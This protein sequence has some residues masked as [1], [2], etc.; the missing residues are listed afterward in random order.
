MSG[1]PAGATSGRDAGLGVSID[2]IPAVGEESMI[3]PAYG[4]QTLADLLPGVGAHLGVPGETDDPLGL[5]SA[6]RYVV[7]LIDGLGWQL[8]R[9]AV[10][11]APYLADLLGEGRPITSGVP[12]TTIT[13]L[14]SLGTGL[15]PGQHGMVGY[16]L[17]VPQTDEI[18]NA[19]AWESSLSPLVFQPRTTIFERARLAGVAVSSV[20]LERFKDSGLTQAALRGGEFVGF[21]K[22]ADEQQRIQLIVDA[23]MCGRR[24]LVYAY[25]RQL[26]HSGH[27]EGCESD[28][29]LQHL[30][31][32]DAMCAQLRDVL[33][34][35]VRMII[36]GD[37]GMLDIPPDNRLIIEDEPEL[38]PGVDAFAGE[39]RFRQLYVDHEEPSVIAARWQDRLGELAWVRTRDEAIDE[40]WFGPVEDRVLQRYGHVLVAMRSDWALMTRKFER[41]LDLIGMHGSLTPA[42]MTVPLLTD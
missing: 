12:S 10:Q 17:R 19:L 7:V 34:D 42:E 5:P 29:W 31:R 28:A 22:E 14:T 38:M 36:T 20:T 32:I 35:E 8:V 1:H 13:S 24:S 33:P 9:R 37:H 26:D 23:A 18:L 3:I 30:I 41:E 25:E 40:G 6:D 21:A 27:V 15:P 39:G 4:Q 11:F 2:S 16:T